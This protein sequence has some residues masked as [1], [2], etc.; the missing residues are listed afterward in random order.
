M[1]GRDLLIGAGLV[2]AAIGFTT[3]FAPGLFG[4]SMT[5][6][7]VTALG[8][9]MVLHATLSI[10]GEDPS[11]E[12]ATTGTPEQRRPMPRPGDEANVMLAGF[13]SVNAGP[14][15]HRSQIRE[16]VI[17]AAVG[18]IAHTEQIPEIDARQLI[19]D[20]V[21]AARR[22][23][24]VIAELDR[25]D[26]ERYSEQ[27]RSVGARLRRWAR[28]R[29][30]DE[31]PLQYDV[32]EA[33]NAIA[34]RLDIPSLD[35][36][37][38]YPEDAAT[39]RDRLDPPTREDSKEDT[40][41]E[42]SWEK[43]SDGL[44]RRSSHETRHWTGMVTLAFAFGG[45]GII[46]TQPPLLLAAAV[47]IGFAAYARHAD[48]A[49]STISVTRSIDPEYP[50]PGEDVT[51]TLTVTNDGTRS[52]LDVRIVDG[53]PE[54]LEVV[55]G[56]PRLGTAL[57]PGESTTVQ[58]DLTATRGLHEFDPVTILTRDPSGTVEDDLVLFEET[59][60]TCV[61]SLRET[62][63]T[64]PLRDLAVGFVGRVAAERGG[65]V[66]FYAVRE[67]RP[68]DPPN[69]IDWNR[70]ART[71]DLATLQFREER[72]T[73]VLLL[74]DTRA[75]AYVAPD[76]AEHAVDRT[77]DAAGRL[78][79]SLVTASN[80]VG[81]ASF[82]P[83]L[84]WL[85]PSLGHHHERQAEDLLGSHPAFGPLPPPERKPRVTWL[86]DIRSRM[87]ED[88]QVVFLTPLCDDFSAFV[89]RRL[90]A[91]GHP[92][93]VVSPDPTSVDTVGGRI[94]YLLRRS[95]MLDLRGA[96]VPVL[97]WSWDQ[98]LETALRRESLRRRGL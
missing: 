77:V 62:G 12:E 72:S 35:A 18:I 68:G 69:R 8:G 47:G 9:L 97:D 67:Y 16:W 87:P 60:V 95:R 40:R 83:D 29:N 90:E 93:S 14:I 23:L 13:D 2:T 85:Q 38:A 51:V 56:V 26:D 7:A 32:R 55:S 88:A 28:W 49:G 4:F 73:T 86:K 17:D 41:L 33:V 57:R 50:D 79:T 34:S 36:D 75:S 91:F 65:G 31:S 45:V 84:C 59:H 78:F 6:V 20:R 25:S 82:G 81:I 80:R 27:A 22:E 54:R 66:E 24:R 63:S 89:A 76:D 98:Q 74:I 43:L 92:V 64:I 1:R 5:E 71:G 42:W 15:R 94:A 30:R 96:G 3:I 21:Y 44:Y 37:T 46:T 48:T 53:V 61:P 39:I 70:H 19:Q 10:V 58:Y 11:L 52:L